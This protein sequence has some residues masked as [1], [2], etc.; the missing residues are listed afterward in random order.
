[1]RIFYLFIVLATFISCTSSDNPTIGPTTTTGNH[2]P[3]LI[4]ETGGWHFLGGQRIPLS[5]QATPLQL[6][7][8]N[9]HLSQSYKTMFYANPDIINTDYARCNLK[10]DSVV[11][12]QVS[13]LEYMPFFYQEGDLTDLRYG[14]YFPPYTTGAYN[15]VTTG[16]YGIGPGSLDVNTKVYQY[17][18]LYGGYSSSPGKFFNP[19]WF[20]YWDV[21]KGGLAAYRIGTAQLIDMAGFYENSYVKLIGAYGLQCDEAYCQAN[22]AHMKCYFAS[23][24]GNYSINNHSRNY[25][26]FYT[27]DDVNKTVFRDSTSQY[28]ATGNILSCSDASSVYYF[29]NKSTVTSDASLKNTKLLM[30]VFDKTTLKLTKKMF[31]SQDFDAIEDIVMLPA[32]NLV[33]LKASL[34][35]NGLFKLNLADNSIT[36]VTPQLAGDNGNT[37]ASLALATDGTKLFATVGSLYL[38]YN[39]AVTN[40][41][42]FE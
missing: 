25:I 14:A 29:I 30:L 2:L 1:M 10:G 5:I 32:K 33:F 9:G 41:I 36:N 35:T 12:K 23:T 7:V 31:W 20:V 26:S 37:I 40:V 34:G 42:Y 24:N 38:K 8:E 18:A 39:P 15:H 16:V 28:I 4:K 6:Q 17:P 22:P 19:H 21:Q 3:V 13:N 27:A 11:M